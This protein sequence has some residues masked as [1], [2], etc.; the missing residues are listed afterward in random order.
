MPSFL[1]SIYPYTSLVFMLLFGYLSNK[2]RMR[3]PFLILGQLLTTLA[4]ICIVYAP[5]Y[6]LLLASLFFGIV[7]SASM[8]IIYMITAESLPPESAGTSFS[9]MTLCQNIGVA[10]SAFWVGY[11]FEITESF[12]FISL[13]LS[14]FAIIGAF[15]ALTIK[16]K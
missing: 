4:L 11:I 8:P 10:L 14:L 3:K 12:L 6:L 9:I 16:G 1:A 13:G 5:D 7:A 2:L 15:M